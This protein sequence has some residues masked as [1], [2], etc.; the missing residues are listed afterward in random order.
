MTLDRRHLLAVAGASA[1]TAAARPTGAPHAA[2]PGDAAINRYFDMVSEQ[3]LAASPETA[4]SLGLDKGKRA[5][6]KSQLSDASMAH[7]V[8]DREWCRAGLAKLATFPDATLSPGARLNKAVVKYAFELGRDA[9][10]FGYGENTMLSAL[11]ESAGPYVVSQQS[12]AYSAVPEFLDSQHQVHT[13]ADAEA[14][15][16][17]VHAMARNLR[18]ETERV[19]K[20]AGLGVVAPDFILA[21]AVGQQEGLL[22]IPADKAR[23]ATALGRKVTEAGLAG[24]Y[25]ARCAAIVEKEVYPALAAQLATLKG[26]QPKAGH[27]AGVWRLPKGDAYYRWLLRQGTTTTLT[28][29]EVHNMGLEQNKAIEARMDGLLRAQG[30]SQGSVGERMT[31][32]GKDPK[33]L[34]PDTDAGREQLIAYL[35]GLIAGVRP[36]LPKA[37]NLKLKAPVIVK[38]VPVDIQDG[39]GQGYMNSGSLDGSRPSTYYINLKSTENWP[40]FSLP[41]LTYHET[42]P[43][44]AWQGAYLT[45]TGKLPLVRILISGFNAYVEGY[46][47]YA[48]QLADEMGMYDDDWAGR[49]GYLQAQK[50]R[51][52][53][54]V[55][56]T[57]LHAKRW[58]REQAVQWA[59]DN[60][61]RTRAAMTSEIDRYCGTPGQACGYKVGHTEINRLRDRAK[62]ALGG[63]YDLRA[64]DDLLVKTGAV[65]LTVL[66]EVVD[67]YVKSGGVADL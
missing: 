19:R 25:E 2:A 60:S 16:A 17:R 10:P 41:S 5:T 67:G 8:H 57:G 24:D 36:K 6:L 35:N 31:A 65:P 15:L 28:P 40:K 34:F 63:K 44:H 43:G 11:S 42:I 22:A 3:Y 48:E 33:H 32:L 52:V 61:G 1:L 23:L 7:V 55:V 13:K 47:L 4:T 50:F 45:E 29:D 56:D 26:L 51:A 38:R 30:L 21:N 9:A 27:D 62:T 53:R 64:F 49:L 12:G 14:Y 39:A 66:G 54:L 59:V 18:Q 20:D 58:S 46:A 37:F